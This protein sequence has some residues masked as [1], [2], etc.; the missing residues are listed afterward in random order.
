[1]LV[2]ALGDSAGGRR[3]GKGTKVSAKPSTV[4]RAELPQ[5]A[6]GA[7]KFSQGV[8]CRHQGRKL[9][10]RAVSHND[11]GVALLE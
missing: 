10:W 1:M 5:S 8:R 6:T 4:R 7:A 9:S 3:Q 2:A 11:T